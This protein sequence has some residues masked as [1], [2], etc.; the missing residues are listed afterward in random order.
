MARKREPNRFPLAAHRI[1]VFKS[2]VELYP[3]PLCRALARGRFSLCRLSQNPHGAVG[4]IDDA[5]MAVIHLASI[6]HVRN[7]PRL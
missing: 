3:V 5:L 6:D 4:A 2:P 1:S 7:F